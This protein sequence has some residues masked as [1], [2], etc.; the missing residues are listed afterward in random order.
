MLIPSGITVDARCEGAELQVTLRD[1]AGKPLQA[2]KPY[3]V[4]ISDFLASGGDN[5]A[6]IMQR[7]PPGA[8]QSYEDLPPLRE[9]VVEALKHHRE[10]PVPAPGSPPRLRLPMPRPVRCG[11]PGATPAPAAE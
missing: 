7:L 9:L 1:P 10:L 3:A 4:A 11:A 6:A 2:D 8:V 5:F